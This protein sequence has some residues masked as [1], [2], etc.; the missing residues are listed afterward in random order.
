MSSPA[1][2]LGAVRGSEPSWA[3]PDSGP[4]TKFHF[5][6]AAR[7]IHEATQDALVGGTLHHAK[8][9]MPFLNDVDLVSTN[10]IHED[11]ALGDKV[12]AAGKVFW[13]YS[14]CNAA[15]PP[16]I[17]RYTFGFYF[18]AFES[19][20][21]VTWAMNFSNRFDLSGSDGWAFSWYT[22]FGTITS[23][24]YEGLREGLDDRRLIETCRRQFKGHP[25][26]EG[27]L[28][29]V[30]KE[31]VESRAKGGTDTVNDFYSSPAEVGKLDLWRNR[32]LDEWLKLGKPR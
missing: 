9:G 28:A 30:L 25:E 17:P 7:L 11:L 32:L 18:G 12:R 8:A 1:S 4:W 5:K 6:D 3:G 21:G 14:G 13:Q 15:Q 24:A 23:P 16:A 2:G 22:P 20:G 19:T 26:A 29:A 10:A 27:V 31:A